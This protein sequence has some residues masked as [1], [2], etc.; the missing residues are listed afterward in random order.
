MRK[1]T[2]YG[3]IAVTLFV[4]FMGTGAWRIAPPR[5]VEANAGTQWNASYFDNRNLNGNPVLTRIDDKIDFNWAAASPGT[6]V[7]ADNFSVRW[8]KTVNFGTSGTWHFRGGADDGIRMWIDTTIIIDQWHDATAGFAVYEVD[9]ANLTAGNHDLKV[10][11]YERTGNAGVQV[12]WTGPGGTGP[13]TTPSSPA[14]SGGEA[15][16]N[17]SYFDNIQ[18]SGNPVLTRIDKK[19]DFNWDS[20]SPGDSVPKNGF[21]ARWTATVNFATPGH[22]KFRVGADD[23]IRMWI[24]NTR[25]FNEWH[26]T[27]NGFT[28]YEVNLYE[29]TAGNHDLKVEYFESAGKAGV[30]VTWARGDMALTQTQTAA[31]SATP[32]PKQIWAGVTADSLNVRSGPG[33]GNPTIATIKYPDNYRVLGAVP[34]MSWVKIALRDGREGWV[35]NEW[36][37]LFSEDDEANKDNNNDTYPDFVFLIPRID[38]PVMPGEF[39]HVEPG[40][41]TVRG[42][43]L[44]VVQLRDGASSRAKHIATIPPGVILLVEARNRNGAWYLVNAE[45][46]RGWAWSPSVKLVEGWIDDLVTSTEVVPAPPAGS[47]FVPVDE[48]GQIRTV[49]GQATEELIVRDAAS[50]RGTEIGRVP[51]GTEFVILGRNTSGA[52]YLLNFEGVEAWVY[53]PQVHLI[54]GSVFDLPIR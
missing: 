51:Q 50:V 22:W 43:T 48:Q 39:T 20:G 15:N 24:D 14:D 19:I 38:I 30:Q 7:P 4:L 42:R 18:L 37:Y 27:P 53:S 41:V 25:I 44:S 28:V 11:Y 35:T 34:D 3:L 1:L 40:P 31:P 5:D 23:G 49:R 13:A 8:T 9:V 29:L 21:G 2:V 52:W 54:E 33:E 6:G 12:S 45:G 32:V 17:A 26:E 16:W 47:L 10:E 46:I 36:V